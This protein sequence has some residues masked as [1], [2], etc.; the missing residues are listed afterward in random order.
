MTTVTPA[1]ISRRTLL[2]SAAGLAACGRPKA[3]RFHG[4]CFVANQRGRSVAVVDLD[5]FRVRKQ[6]P[7]DAAPAAVCSHPTKA[8]VFVLAPDA[9][10]VYEI[11]GASLAIARSARGG[12]QA[13]A[14]RVSP[15]NDALWVLYRDPPSLVEFPLASLRPNRRIRLSAPPDDFDLSRDGQAAIATSKGCNVAIASLARSSIVRTIAADEEPSIVRFHW[16]GTQV[17]SGSR[18]ARSL[19][20]FDVATGNVVVR[21]PLPLA[22]RHF[23]FT[24]DAQ[25]Q[26]FI[27]GDGSDGIAIVFPY[28]TEVDQTVLA[29]RA[30]GAMAVTSKAPSFLL[31]SNPASNG[32]TVLD[33][34]S[35]KLIAVVQVGQ[36]PGQILLTPDEE[37]ALVL[38]QKSGDLA[39]IR[40]LSLT[41]APD[42]SRRRFKSAPLF[43]LIP[44]GEGPVSA[45]VL[46]LG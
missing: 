39:V 21:L 7:L 38:G 19:T 36:E 20:I 41:V 27:S 44:V 22:P 10:T 45:A 34:D 33:V 2:L 24:A 35:R 30:P 13:V 37:Y 29:G 46:D 43:T 25:G 17:L 18:E 40:V 42:G 31:V 23:C 16:T 11:D 26:L 9:G 1:E 4:F 32:V 14:M 6:I 5:R 15:A 8:K 28:T 3:P 12:N